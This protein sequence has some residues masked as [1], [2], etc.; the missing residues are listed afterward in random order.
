MSCPRFVPLGLALALLTA[1]AA[2]QETFS[3]GR[4]GTVTLYQDTAAPHSLALFVSGDGGWNRGVV[5]MA[6][7]I[8]SGGGLVAGIDITHYRR[9]LESSREACVYPAADFEALSKFIQKKKKFPMYLP[10]VLIGYS[11]GATLVYA[12]LV[13]APVNTFAGAISLGFCPDLPLRKPLCRGY[14]LEW[15]AAPNVKGYSFRPAPG[16][17]TPWIVL[18]GD[19]DQ[20]CSPVDTET[21]VRQTGKASLIALDKVGHG[22]SVQK[23]WL[24]QFKEAFSQ[25]LQPS[26]E[27]GTAAPPDISD[28]P[29]IEVPP[30]QWRQDLLAV[31]LSGDGGWAS[32]DRS[33]GNTLADR[34]IGVVGFNSLKYF[35]KRRTPEEAGR[36]LERLLRYYLKIWKKP[37]AML[38]GYSLGADVLPFMA[39]RLAPEVAEK[40][41][42]IGLLG[43]S[44]TV[45]FEFHIVEWLGWSRKKNALPLL[46]E[47]EKLRGK[48]ILCFF[49][50]NESDSL[51]HLLEPGLAICIRLGG[52][53]H[54]GGDYESIAAR[55]LKELE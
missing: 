7:A 19:I 38:I 31:I 23:N 42:L 27:V 47:V 5:D 35:W 12:T 6:R 52:G 41:Q 40:I 20:I 10:P 30:K 16:L 32:I 28:L 55:I 2:G 21:F 49:G 33:L 17:Q 43:P 9:Q 34:G 46:P 53:H 45:D 24:P 37:R 51:C 3:F 44:R 13:Q 48:K 36:D 50:A 11:S 22:F 8:A 25:L 54:F 4:F 29:L 26:S 14:G 18:Q 1:S 39:N 15:T